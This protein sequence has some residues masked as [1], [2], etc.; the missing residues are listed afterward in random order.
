VGLS[1]VI[2]QTLVFA[3]EE[4]G[5]HDSVYPNTSQRGTSDPDACRWIREVFEHRSGDEWPQMLLES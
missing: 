1:A 3:I 4:L 2:N 5:G